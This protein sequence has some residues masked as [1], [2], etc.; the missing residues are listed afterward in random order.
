MK[1]FEQEYLNGEYREEEDCPRFEKIRK[2]KHQH[3]KH[4]RLNK[5]ERARR[6]KIRNIKLDVQ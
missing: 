6:Q 5:D 2:R 3:G 4:E 1:N